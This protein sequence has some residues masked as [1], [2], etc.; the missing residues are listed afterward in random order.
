MKHKSY[1]HIKITDLNICQNIN[2]NI[3]EQF[4][5]RKYCIKYHGMYILS[6]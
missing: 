3:L 4:N 2:N 6:E 5:I 1:K